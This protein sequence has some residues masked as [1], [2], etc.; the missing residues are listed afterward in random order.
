MKKLVLGALLTLFLI[1]SG[2]SKSSS[3]DEMSADDNVITD[4]DPMTMAMPRNYED[5]IKG[6]ISN[7]CLSCHTNPPVNNAP[8]S[9]ETYTD[10]KNAVENRSLLS[11]I[12]NS[13]NP[14]PPNG[15]LPSATRQIIEDW[16]DQGLPE[17]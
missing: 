14:M 17:N 15:L 3:S 12:N 13:A 5:D 6:V 4:D 10:V 7:N 11:R 1:I 9:L 2:C 8:M 16:I